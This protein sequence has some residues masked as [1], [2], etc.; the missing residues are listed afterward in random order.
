MILCFSLPC[1]LHSR[2]QVC[3]TK[4]ERPKKIAGNLSDPKKIAEIL[5]DP[6]K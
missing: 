5:R 2:I 4:I 3:D 6:E 1:A